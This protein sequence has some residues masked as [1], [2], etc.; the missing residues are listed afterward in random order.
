[1]S[2]MICLFP[3][4]VRLG[5]CWPSS[6]SPSSLKPCTKTVQHFRSSHLLQVCP[7]PSHTSHLLLPLH[8]LGLILDCMF[9]C[10]YLDFPCGYVLILVF[11]LFPILI[12]IC[13]FE[14]TSSYPRFNSCPYYLFIYL[15][16][17]VPSAILVR[18][19]N[20]KCFNAGIGDGKANEVCLH[21]PASTCHMPHATCQL[22]QATCHMPP[23][24]RHLSHA[25]CHLSHATCHMLPVTCHMPPV[26]YSPPG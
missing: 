15:S 26:T 6:P 24:T 5:L 4:N 25:T 21:S 11:I 8:I 10:W 16:A 1:M 7:S 12:T 13:V 3:R 17:A 19:A 18:S 22:S 9:L 2:A 23:V 20:V 14:Y